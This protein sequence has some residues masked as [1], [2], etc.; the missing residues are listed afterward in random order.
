MSTDR[1]AAVVLL[2]FCAFMGCLTTRIS[3]ATIAGAPSPRTFP[4]IMLVL[5]TVLSLILL[6][7]GVG[8]E[9]KKREPFG[10]AM[11]AYFTI[12]AYLALVPVT[13]FLIATPVG[14]FVLLQWTVDNKVKSLL[15]SLF[16]TAVLYL[17]FHTAL[18]IRLP[19]SLLF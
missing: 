10:K 2:T 19:A 8:K 14:L 15:F 16:I 12:C 7:R 6:I 13:G 3:G 4:I 1:K 18:G 11:L 9:E 17:I 5:L